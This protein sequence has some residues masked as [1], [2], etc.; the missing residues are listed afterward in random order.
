MKTRRVREIDLQKVSYASV[1]GDVQIMLNWNL[2]VERK[3]SDG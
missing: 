1:I 2:C 3:V